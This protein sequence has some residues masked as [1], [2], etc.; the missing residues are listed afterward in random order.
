MGAAPSD[1]WP[2]SGEYH[3]GDAP[4]QSL[5][6]TFDRFHCADEFGFD[7]VTVAEHDYSAFSLS[8]NPMVCGNLR[9]GTIFPACRVTQGPRRRE[10]AYGS[11]L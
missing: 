9:Q 8:P 6:T 1:T 11:G 5:Q 7:W 3:S 4:V 2:L 10:A